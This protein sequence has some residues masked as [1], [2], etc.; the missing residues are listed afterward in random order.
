MKKEN[1]WDKARNVRNSIPT[2]KFTN[3]RDTKCYWSIDH[4]CN[5]AWVRGVSKKKT[6]CDKGEEYPCHTEL[7]DIWA[8][9]IKKPSCNKHKRLLKE[10]RL[11]EGNE[12]EW[13]EK[14]KG[15][16]E[17]QQKKPLEQQLTDLMPLVRYHRDV[18]NAL[19]TKRMAIRQKKNEETMNEFLNR[20]SEI[21]GQNKKLSRSINKRIKCHKCKKRGHTRRN[22]PK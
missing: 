17:K 2:R 20:L 18:K 10:Y 11:Q 1:K 8:E 7:K 12:Q 15:L 21:Y 14:V 19:K 16:M 3:G 22:C 9:R 4:S 13:I 5:K 6:V